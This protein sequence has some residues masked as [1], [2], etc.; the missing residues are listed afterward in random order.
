MQ[1]PIEA[2]RAGDMQHG[3]SMHEDMRWGTANEGNYTK[4]VVMLHTTVDGATQQCQNIHRGHM[5]PL[6]GDFQ[7]RQVIV[8]K[9]TMLT[10]SNTHHNA[11]LLGL[12][13]TRLPTG[14][15]IEVGVMRCA[16]V[17]HRTVSHQHHDRASHTC[18]KPRMMA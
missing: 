6:D 17:L 3:V 11:N 7:L 2:G 18:G 12:V 5:L 9:I 10:R 1:D 13:D 15:L 4:L 8:N 14:M 16:S